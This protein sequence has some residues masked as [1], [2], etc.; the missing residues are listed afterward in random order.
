MPE[1]LYPRYLA[2]KRSVDG[3]AL[4][5]RVW[6]VLKEH[7]PLADLSRGLELP[8]AQVERGELVLI[9]HPFDFLASLK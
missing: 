9:A 1:F 7:L 3:R 8:W 6:R 5:W 2:S 4:N